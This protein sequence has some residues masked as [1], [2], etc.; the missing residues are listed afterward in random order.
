MCGLSQ[1]AMS[2]GY[3]SLQCTGF[4]LQW[5]LLLQSMGSRHGGFSKLWCAGS[6]C[7]LVCGI[8]LDQISNPCHLHWQVDSYPMYHQGSPQYSSYLSFDHLLLEIFFLS[9][10]TKTFSKF[11]SCFYYLLLL[12]I[13]FFLVLQKDFPNF[14][15]ASVATLSWDILYLSIFLDVKY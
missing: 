11:S 14:L 8:F 6:S 13:F 10:I 2:R 3:C 5:L 4:S 1:V 15:P 7:P 12:E 9:G